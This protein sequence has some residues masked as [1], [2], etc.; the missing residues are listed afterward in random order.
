MSQYILFVLTILVIV[1]NSIWYY[2]KHIVRNN[3]YET[4]LFWGHYG[5]LINLKQIISKEDDRNKKTKYI[6]VQLSLYVSL[7]LFALCIVL[8]IYKDG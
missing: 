8:L 6:Y 4:N 5:D 1:I 3:G 2:I 7:L